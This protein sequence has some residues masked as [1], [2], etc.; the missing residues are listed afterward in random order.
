MGYIYFKIMAVSRFTTCGLFLTKESM[1]T[2][3]RMR[4]RVQVP[5]AAPYCI[6]TLEY[7][8]YKD[9]LCYY[10][11][12]LYCIP[13]A[14]VFVFAKKFTLCITFVIL[15]NNKRALLSETILLYPFNVFIFLKLTVS[16]ARLSAAS[17]P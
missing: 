12:Y 14:N 2:M 1:I 6:Y 15:A 10:R 7:V 16:T 5:K 4:S 11:G 9:D 17:F 3:V 8:F 13:V